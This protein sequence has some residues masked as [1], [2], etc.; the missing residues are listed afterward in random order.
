MCNTV[1]FEDLDIN[2][3]FVDEAHNCKN[4][5]IKI[6]II[7]VL[8]ISATGSAKCSD[9][10]E[11][12]R[13]VQTQNNG[14]GVVF[15]TGTPITNSL[16]DAYVMQKYLQ[17]EEMSLINLKS[18]DAWIGMFAEKVT[19]A[20]IGVDTSKFRMTTRFLKFHNLPELGI[21]LAA[22]TDFHSIDKKTAF[23]IWQNILMI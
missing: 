2:T 20:E 13:I 15:A 4:L 19:E 22:V 12:I 8:G 10:Y 14:R 6:K 5:T 23:R 18:F 9:M 7:N 17:F 1:C 16:T 21:L 11:K 3:L